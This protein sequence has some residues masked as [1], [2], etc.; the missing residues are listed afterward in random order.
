MNN[1]HE[2]E[3]YPTEPFST[4]KTQLWVATVV[5]SLGGDENKLREVLQKTE[6]F[7]KYTNEI[8]GPIIEISIKSLAKYLQNDPELFVKGLLGLTTSIFIAGYIEGQ[9]RQKEKEHF[10]N[11]F[12]E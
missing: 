10:N 7:A 6:E 5:E 9:S 11:I 8:S 3:Y 1:L 2:K 12:S 4:E